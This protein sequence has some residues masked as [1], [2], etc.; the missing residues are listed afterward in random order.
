MLK[1]IYK[2]FF[3]TLL[4]QVLQIEAEGHTAH[5]LCKRIKRFINWNEGDWCK[6]AQRKSNCDTANT[7]LA[8]LAST[9][10]SLGQKWGGMVLTPATV[11]RFRMPGKGVTSVRMDLCSWDKSCTNWQLEVLQLLLPAAKQQAFPSRRICSPYGSAIFYKGILMK[12]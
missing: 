7:F 3:I 1:Y 2:L 8:N 4:T 11:T 9:L 5:L 10:S 6:T 12:T